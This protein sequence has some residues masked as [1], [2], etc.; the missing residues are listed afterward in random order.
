MFIKIMFDYC[1][2]SGTKQT[3]R[4]IMRILL[5]VTCSNDSNNDRN[6]HC[7]LLLTGP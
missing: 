5:I 7:L 2:V 6:V 1:Y 4:L 3:D